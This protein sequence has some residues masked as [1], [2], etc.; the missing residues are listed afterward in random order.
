MESNEFE[1]ARGTKQRDPVS[2]PLFNSVLQ[3]AM[4][5]DIGTW[6]EK[7]LGIKLRDEKRDCM[8]TVNLRFADDVLMMANSL[9]QLKKG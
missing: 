8:V 6:N 3:L 9:K 4:E 7:G 1:I 2:S 5:K